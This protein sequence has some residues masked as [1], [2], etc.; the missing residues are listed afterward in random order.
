M[1]VY[2]DYVMYESFPA[3]TQK[4]TLSTCTIENVMQLLLTENVRKLMLIENVS[5]RCN[6][7][8]V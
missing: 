1:K 2:Y 4:T 5:V 7:I 8:F 3:K 6:T